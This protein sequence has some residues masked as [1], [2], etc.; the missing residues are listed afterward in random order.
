MSQQA[1]PDIEVIDISD[2][3]E[4]VDLIGV[5]DA[6]TV[7]LSDEEGDDTSVTS[8]T[9]GVPPSDSF[10]QRI[11]EFT[12]KEEAHGKLEGISEAMVSIFS[13]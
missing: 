11:Q 12:L 5:H 6:S 3:E 10:Q 1:R 8:S 7:H 13:L 9:E 4:Q 2:D